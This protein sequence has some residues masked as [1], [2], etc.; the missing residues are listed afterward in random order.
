MVL[1]VAHTPDAF[2]RPAIKDAQGSRVDRRAR[3]HAGSAGEVPAKG[4]PSSLAGNKNTWTR[5][6]LSAQPGS[7]PSAEA[8]P[9]KPVERTP[10]HMGNSQHENTAWADLKRKRIGESVQ[11]RSANRHRGSGQGGPDRKSLRRGGYS[12]QRGSASSSSPRAALCSSC[13][14][15]ARRSSD[16]ASG[17]K[18]TCT[19][20]SHFVHDLGA[21]VFP[22]NRVNPTLRDLAGTPVKLLRPRRGDR[23]FRF[24]KAAQDFF[25]HPRAFIARQLQNLT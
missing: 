16:W 3:K 20:L 22:C 2:L 13:Q 21:R 17:C 14:R 7:Q 4:V 25:R 6:H 1:N 23:V 10:F 5:P 8:S 24:L 12:L 18:S 19:T 11:Q 9:P 15:A